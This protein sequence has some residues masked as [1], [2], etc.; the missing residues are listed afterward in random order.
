LRTYLT[1]AG[2]VFSAMEA[3]QRKSPAISRSL[4]IPAL[5]APASSAAAP[6]PAYVNL[7][8]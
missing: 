2:S 8:L 3:F 7:G 5:L 6:E 1:I 4:R